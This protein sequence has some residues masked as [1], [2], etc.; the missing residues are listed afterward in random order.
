M[1]AFT[2]LLL[3]LCTTAT[4]SS[5][6]RPKLVVL[7]VSSAP[8]LGS[9]S[10]ATTGVL[11]SALSQLQVFDVTSSEEVRRALSLERQRALLGAEGD[12][13]SGTLDLSEALKTDFVV[14]GRLTR[15][16]GE[17]QMALLTLE[18]SLSEGTKLSRLSAQTVS[19]HS[20][21]ELMTALGPTVLKLCAPVLKGL[22]GFLALSVA[23]ERATVKVD[24]A[25]LGTTPLSG[26]LELPA[27]PHLVEV[28]KE[29]FVG[30]R[31]EV[32]V[33]PGQLTDETLTLMPS[34]DFIAAYDRRANKMRMGAYA[35][36]GASAAALAGAL[37]FHLRGDAIYG[38]ADDPGTFAF[39][40]ARLSDAVEQENGVDNR[41]RANDLK[42]QIQTTQ[43]LTAALSA[44]GLGAAAGAVYLY[45][46]GDPPGRYDRF[47]VVP[48]TQGAAAS[49]SFWF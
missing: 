42:A 7:D 14:G 39:H 3:L 28:E 20:E 43:T 15:S 33:Q 12:V 17:G 24:G 46:A 22:S 2:V 31:R 49:F 41:A 45:I 48:T 34:P 11:A 37:M 16:A 5:A 6:E 40:R 19:A 47:M 1:S 4:P 23:E 18:L 13:S 30:A 10:S 9:L 27:G 25:V 29:G 35:L 32:R 21:A 8:E 36:G 38:S 44:V 26:R